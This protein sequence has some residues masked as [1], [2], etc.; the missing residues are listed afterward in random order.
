MVIKDHVIG[1]CLISAS[2]ISEFFMCVRVHTHILAQRSG[3]N[4]GASDVEDKFYELLM[5]ECNN[6]YNVR[7]VEKA[8]TSFCG[9]GE[10]FDRTNTTVL[11]HN[12]GYKIITVAALYI[13]ASPIHS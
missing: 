3:M 9:I 8:G 6:G 7:R 13:V 1:S 5:Y 12:A 2:F 10:G 4:L 11:N